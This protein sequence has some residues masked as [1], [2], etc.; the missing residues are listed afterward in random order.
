MFAA[1]PAWDARA[2]E[3]KRAVTVWTSADA[4]D[5]FAF[6][7]DEAAHE[8]QDLRTL[9][10]LWPHLH[11]AM[12]ELGDG[13]EVIESATP[14][15]FHEATRRKLGMVGGLCSTRARSESKSP[16]ARTI[17]PNLFLVGDTVSPGNGVD[18]V[19]RSALRLA[20]VLAPRR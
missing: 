9:E 11:A 6:H 4:S 3:G 19:S 2:P 18:A 20:D 16:F 13:I 8:K 1:A 5:W 7:Q 15:T 10:H 14:R 12:P 17:F